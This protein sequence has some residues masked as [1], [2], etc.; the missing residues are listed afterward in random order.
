MSMLKYFLILRKQ[1]KIENYLKFI[2]RKTE[3]F[4]EQGQYPVI[5]LSLKGFKG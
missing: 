5:F 3:N 2:Y 1:K 4:K